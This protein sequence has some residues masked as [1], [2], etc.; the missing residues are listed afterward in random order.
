MRFV[1]T[2]TAVSLVVTMLLSGCAGGNTAWAFESN[3]KTVPAGLYIM[4][5]INA[6]GAAEEKLH[7]GSST[8]TSLSPKELLKQTVEGVPAADWIQTHAEESVREHIAVQQKFDSMGLTLTESEIAAVKNSV[9]SIESDAT[10][11]YKK[12]GISESSLMEFYMGYA[13]QNRLFSALYGEGGELAVP[14]EQLKSYFTEKY[15]MVDL[16][17]LYK[18]QSVPEGET[19]TLEQLN[20]EVKTAG[21]E[22]LKRLQGGEAIEDLVYEWQQKEAP[23]DQKASIKK[24]EKGQLSVVV[25]EASRTSYGEEFTDAA[26][27]SKIDD[28]K[29][30][31]DADFVMVFKR[32]DITANPEVFETYKATILQELKSDEFDSKLK[33]W[34][35]ATQIEVNNAALERYKPSK[36]NFDEPK[37]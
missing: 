30:V 36:I 2:V 31:E 24:P 25:S 9:G 37:K 4:H 23:E 13:R 10:N 16:M 5:Q 32:I 8:T 19:K 21:E 27:K 3:D 28:C 1:K 15:A 33:E 22:Y 12:N 29:L 26:M 18:H 35:A 11:F 6:F 14:I 20:A 17:L 7:E 34:A